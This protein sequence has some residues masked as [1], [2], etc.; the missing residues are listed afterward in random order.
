MLH[1]ELSLIHDY[2]LY[3]CIYMNSRASSINLQC[4]K[5]QKQWLRDMQD[6]IEIDWEGV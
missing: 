3:D 5:I 4:K 2:M 6:G 1:T